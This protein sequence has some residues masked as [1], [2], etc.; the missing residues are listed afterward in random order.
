MSLFHPLPSSMPIQERARIMVRRGECADFKAAMA[1]LSS[2]RRSSVDKVG[3]VRPIHPIAPAG[4]QTQPPPC[5]L[6]YKDD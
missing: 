4:A 6:P 5:R 2:F 1:K 3:L